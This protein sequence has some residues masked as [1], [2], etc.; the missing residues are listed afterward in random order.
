VVG[1]VVVEAV[2]GEDVAVSGVVPGLGALLPSKA[3]RPHFDLYCP[4]QN[5]GSLVH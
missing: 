4:C 3:K 2:T 1:A 5:F